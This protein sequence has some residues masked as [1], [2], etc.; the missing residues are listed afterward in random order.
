MTITESD[1]PAHLHSIGNGRKGHGCPTGKMVMPTVGFA[2]PP[3][4]TQYRSSQ[5]AV[6]SISGQELRQLLCTQ[7]EG[8]HW[9]GLLHKTYRKCTYYFVSTYLRF[10]PAQ[11]IIAHAKFKKWVYMQL[12]YIIVT[13][14]LFSSGP[15]P[16]QPSKLPQIWIPQ[17]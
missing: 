14:I 16:F 11:P 13:S 4:C 9:L 2:S 3:T 17:Q 6:R 10:F 15:W 8:T 7:R 12:K 1:L 5:G